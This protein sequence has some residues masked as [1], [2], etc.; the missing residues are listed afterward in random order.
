MLLYSAVRLK[1]LVLYDVERDAFAEALFFYS[2]CGG[3]RF[4][5]VRDS[6]FVMFWFLLLFVFCR[7]FATFDYA[8]SFIRSCQGLSH[9][10]LS[11]HLQGINSWEFS[12]LE[13]N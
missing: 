8:L 9:D 4:T 1:I 3:K 5:G 11:I 2:C 7:K 6:R 12:A 13:I 10:L